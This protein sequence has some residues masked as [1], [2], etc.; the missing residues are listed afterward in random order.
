MGHKNRTLTLLAGVAILGWIA[1][2]PARVPQSRAT[3]H[4]RATVTPPA[5]NTADA[6]RLNNLGV[7]QMNRQQTEAALK[8]FERAY[9]L[10]PKLYAARLNQGI[11]LLYLQRF[12]P[13]RKIVT[14]ATEREPQNPRAWYNIGL[15]EKAQ[16][17][18]QPAIAAFERVAAFD[19]SDPDAHY[20]LGQLY[21]QQSDFDKAIAAYQRAIALN[22]FHV[23]AE[24]GLAQTYQRKGDTASAQ[25]H[26]ARF[27]H[28]TQEKLGVPMS[29]VYGEQGKY[30]LAEQTTPALA[31][32]PPTI[33]VRFADV[34]TNA[35]L[36]NNFAGSMPSPKTA[37][38]FLGAGACV[39][40]FDGD[41]RP[42][43][44]LA[45]ADGSGSSALYHN[46][47][48]GKFVDVTKAAGLEAHG[49]IACAA[50]DYDNDGHTD[51]GVG[52]NGRVAVYRNQG[53]GT[54]KEVTAAAGIQ[55]EGLISG[56]AFI[57]YDH[58]GD[59]DLY[60]TRMLDFSFKDSSS[61]PPFLPEGI[62]HVTPVLW[63]NNGN[64]TFTNW[65]EQ[66][67]LG[68]PSSSLGALA[69]DLDNDHAVD[70]IVT[71]WGSFPSIFMNP[72]EGK[73][74]AVLPWG[75]VR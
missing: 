14:E 71:A 36:A 51:L 3:P 5:P 16:G 15:L 42:D 10:D 11:A 54:F 64:G 55:T 6:V 33:S 38:A 29:L 46:S 20:F 57:D 56:L 28:I 68:S 8:S 13:A 40:D 18:T 47:G 58:D 75:V 67:G 1:I 4:S 69:S 25:E 2:A 34:T 37:A 45:N 23:S 74:N 72:R 59:V 70:L 24:F 65:T 39:V 21:A 49:A 50:G 62:A 63:R 12:E 66:T 52:F 27:Q 43:I 30:S 32:V 7:A 35:G 60:I 9:A 19:P 31:S 48:G 44:F 53:D 41:G 17:N 26:L 22:P 73:F 61:L